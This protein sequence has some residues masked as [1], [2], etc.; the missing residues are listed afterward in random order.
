MEENGEYIHKPSSQPHIN[1]V[2]QIILTYKL[3]TLILQSGKTLLPEKLKVIIQ[4]LENKTYL[5]TFIVEGT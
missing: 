1:K 4:P 2:K 5:V 3:S